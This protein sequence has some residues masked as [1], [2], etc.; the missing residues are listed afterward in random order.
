M[1]SVSQSFS[2]YWSG[3]RED[4]LP[5]RARAMQE[6]RQIG[7]DCLEMMRERTALGETRNGGSFRGYS[8]NYI[9]SKRNMIRSGSFPDRPTEYRASKVNDYARLSGQYMSSWE[10]LRPVV[11]LDPNAV[12]MTIDLRIRNSKMVKRNNYL[13]A[14]GRDVFGISDAGTAA[15]QRERRYLMARSHARLGLNARARGSAVL[16]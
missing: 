12:D 8:A 3:V 10:A 15:G 9:R 5:S 6:A 1:A 16:V 4:L 11:S 7:Q 14:R 13:K 2:I